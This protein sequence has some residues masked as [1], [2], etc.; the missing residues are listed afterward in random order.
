VPPGQQEKPQ[1]EAMNYRLVITTC[2]SMEEAQGLAEKLLAA[3]LAA[4]INIVPGIQS[5]YEWQGK[6]ERGQEFLL[7]IKSRSDRFAELERLV[8]KNHSYELPELIA[9]PIE[10]GSAPY[11]RW[12]DA[13]LAQRG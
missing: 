8:Q 1:G 5:L 7:L 9:L 4:C 13:A 12:I 2:P 10:A 3:R 6:V 11:L